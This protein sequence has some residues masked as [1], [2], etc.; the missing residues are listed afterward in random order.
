MNKNN[1]DLKQ[2]RKNQRLTQEEF[3]DILDVSRS[4]IT[5]IEGGKIEL[6]KKMVKKLKKNF[7]NEFGLPILEPNLIGNL[8]HSDILIS[9]ISV[10]LISIEHTKHII[11]KMCITSNLPYN[12][13]KLTHFLNKCER[14]NFN[15]ELIKYEN[16]DK[17]SH[18]VI[19]DFFKISKECLNGI[20]EDLFYLSRFIYFQSDK[21][22]TLDDFGSADDWTE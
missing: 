6:S 22:K 20:Y 5:K 8:E 16:S 19:S 15:D 17:Y 10:D 12:R 4:I 7:P 2:I 21:N 9:I 13:Q 1:I 14:L 3:S 11:K 18:K